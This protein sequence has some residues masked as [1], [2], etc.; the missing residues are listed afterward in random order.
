ML[1]LLQGEIDLAQVTFE[2]PTWSVR[3]PITGSTW[4][5]DDA[6]G[7]VTPDERAAER[8]RTCRV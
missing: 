2:P 3:L 8:V 6:S 5:V 4:K 1:G 7:A